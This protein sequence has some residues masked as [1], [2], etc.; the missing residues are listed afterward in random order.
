[1]M[2]S[3]GLKLATQ[4]AIL[5]ANYIAHRLKDHYPILYKGSNGNVAH[6]CIIDIRSIK[7]EIGITEEDIAKRLIEYLNYPKELLTL[8]QFQMLVRN[9][10]LLGG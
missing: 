9:L 6:E 5:N 8:L 10:L 4:V 1:M 3:Q 2:G 7:S